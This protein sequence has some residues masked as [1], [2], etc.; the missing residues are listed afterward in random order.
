MSGIV[1]L[2]DKMVF[3][4]AISIE[5]KNFPPKIMSQYHTHNNYFSKVLY[6]TCLP[7]LSWLPVSM[8]QNR[9]IKCC[10]SIQIH[11]E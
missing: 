10:F 8:V 7:R 11:F 4:Y 6:L 1:C 9:A 2:N 5:K 3:A